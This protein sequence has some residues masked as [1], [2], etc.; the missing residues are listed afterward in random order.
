MKEFNNHEP[1]ET[2]ESPN[3]S[4]GER[5]ASGSAWKRLL[6]K[7]WVFPAIY[8]VAVAI[9]LSIMWAYQ[10]SGDKTLDIN[11]AGL[12]LETGGTDTNAPLDSEE[13]GLPVTASTENMHWPVADPAEVEVVMPYYEETLSHEDKLAA[14]IQLDEEFYLSQGISLAKQDDTPFEVVAALSGTV[15]RVDMLPLLGHMVEITHDDGLR[16]YYQSLSNVTVSLH[17]QV[18]QGDVIGEAGRNELQKELGVHLHFEV[19]Q[20]EASVNPVVMLPDHTASAE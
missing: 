5:K 1:N 13:E 10:S 15:T 2:V 16:T 4:P 18:K 12:S 19:W 17:D 3:P 11:E 14:T 6:A 9:I 8:M 20:D 7:K